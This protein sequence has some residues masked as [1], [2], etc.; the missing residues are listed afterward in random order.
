MDQSDIK[1]GSNRSFGIVF[2][3]VFLIIS[4]YPILNNENVRIW[5]LHNFIAETGF[6]LIFDD[7]LSLFLIYEQIYELGVGYS[8]K[9]NLALG[10]LPNKETKYTFSL[11]ESEDLVSNF[12]IKKNINDYD[13]SFNLGENLMNL[14]EATDASIYINKVF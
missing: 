13:I 7:N 1:I 8:N 6:D 14:G 12:E 10:Y 11:K 4:I 9:L 5:A 3:I 2:F